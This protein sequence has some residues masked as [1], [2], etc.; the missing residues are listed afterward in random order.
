MASPA[1]HGVVVTGMGAVTPLGRSAETSWEAV[2]AGK[3]GVDRMPA[4]VEAELPVAIGAPVRGDLGANDLDPKERRRLDR[5]ILLALTA[6]EEAVADA[7]IDFST[8]ESGRAGVVIGSG[9]GGISTIVENH[10]SFLSRGHRRVSPFMI[11]MS[12]TN[13][14]G[15]YV[16]IRYGLT[17][18]IQCPVSACASG[19][20]ALGEAARIIER[21]DADVVIAG[22]TEASLI[23]FVAAG[24]QSMQAL[25]NR[26]DAPEQA[27]RPFDRDR[28]GFVMGEGAGLFILERAEHARARGAKIRG[29]L[30]GYGVTADASHVAAP[31]P[32][33]RGA[34]ACMRRALEDAERDATDVGYVNAHATSTPLG[35]RIEAGVIRRVVGEAVAVSSTKGATGHLFG[36]AGAVEALFCVR[37]LETGILPPTLNLEQPD[38]ECELAHVAMTARSS[39]PRV[40]LSN[41]FGFGGTNTCLVLG[42]EE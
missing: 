18:P 1:K 4:F 30:L 34:E 36:A 35:D 29:H 39:S 5:A 40:A 33:G 7:G 17:G 12:L 9:I 42:R 21:G 10:K 6:A 38:E 14:P 31:E 3:S 19:A 32:N 26:N 23:P 15:G 37:A 22:G 20:Q 24:F 28:D 2:V 41:S 8:V 27:S 16:A 25:S 11:P 13:L